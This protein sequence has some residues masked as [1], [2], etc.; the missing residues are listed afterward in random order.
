MVPARPAERAIWH[1]LAG[2]SAQQTP[3][4]QLERTQSA[5]CAVRAVLHLARSQ[6]STRPTVTVRKIDG[7]D[8]EELGRF[9]VALSPEGRRSRF[10][11]ASSGIPDKSS[12]SLCS[13][14]HEHEEGFVAIRRSGGTADGEIV[15]H[16]CL[17]PVH[18]STVELAVAVA[19]EHQ[20]RGI[21][22]RLLVAALAWA[23]EH[24]VTMV[25]ASAY[26]GNT[27]VLR[28]LSTSPEARIH[29]VGAGVVEIEILLCEPGRPRPGRPACGQ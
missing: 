16:L 9:Y 5:A 25:S 2:R 4:M 24:H 3:S 20:G 1:L 29:P 22:R 18:D 21:A 12:R 23:G 11:G 8:R 14:D 13:P 7:A 6:A 17:V 15:G 28:L 19:D 10:L 26:A 27:A